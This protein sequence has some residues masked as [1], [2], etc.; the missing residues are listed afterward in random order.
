MNFIEEI[1]QNHPNAVLIE[2]TTHPSFNEAFDTTTLRARMEII[3]DL[4][5]GTNNG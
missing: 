3:P 2:E 4:T 1:L 5:G